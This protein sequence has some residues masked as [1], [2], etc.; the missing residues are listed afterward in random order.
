LF[1]YGR[2]LPLVSPGIAREAIAEM[3]GRRPGLLP[4]RALRRV[5][6]PF[7]VVRW[8]AAAVLPLGAVILA[9]RLPSLAL[10]RASSMSSLLAAVPAQEAPAAADAT[11]QVGELR[12]DA[13]PTAPPPVAATEAVAPVAD[14][15]PAPAAS[16]PAPVSDPEVAGDPPAAEPP[17]PRKDDPPPAPQVALAGYEPA[18]ATP[19]T[20]DTM[21][22]TIP[23]GSTLL[24]LLRSVYGYDVSDTR[25][26][27]L[28][29]EILRLNPHVRDVNMIIAGDSLRIPRPA[30]KTR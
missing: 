25:M 28:F 6:P 10:S 12:R 26:K 4:R 24:G 3:D 5:A 18:P 19:A 30:G 21:H 13:T 9:D 17:S 11:A 8:A 15:A 23:H 20:A 7:R 1:A 22:V 2:G 27:E 16:A 14:S 29:S